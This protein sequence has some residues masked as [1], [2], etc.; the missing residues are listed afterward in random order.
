[1]VGPHGRELEDAG[2]AARPHH[3]LRDRRVLRAGPV[4]AVLVLHDGLHH[5]GGAA[6][7]R[8]HGRRTWTTTCA[9]CRCCTPTTRRPSAEMRPWAERQ[10][11]GEVVVW[12][13]LEGFFWF[14]RTLMGI[15][16][17]I[18]A[19]YDQPELI[20]RINGDLC[21]FNLR[22]LDEMCAVCVPTFM[23]IAEDMSYNHGP[24]MSKALFDEFL[25]PV[26]PAAGAAA[27]R[28]GRD[29]D[30]GHRRRRDAHGAL[31]GGG[32]GAGR[33]APGTAGGRG[34]DAHPAGAPPGR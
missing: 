23:T 12:V 17:E 19:F 10:A 6:P 20:H 5:R 33:A 27:A 11:R 16:R 30:R 14:P 32:R 15:E 13:T 1:M 34:R 28:A 26:L 24:M 21:D 9:S 8:G 7:R 3:G 4:P 18:Y 29:R 31:A 25:A 22:V 2:P